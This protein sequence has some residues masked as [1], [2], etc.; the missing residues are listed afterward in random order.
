MI[1]IDG[2]PTSKIVASMIRQGSA[3]Y[4]RPR[5]YKSPEE[6]AHYQAFRRATQNECMR[7]LR[8]QRKYV[9]HW[10]DLI[11]RRGGE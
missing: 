9:E 2:V 6:R 7:R 1:T 5:H 3:Q 10:L 8:S 4:P 11:F